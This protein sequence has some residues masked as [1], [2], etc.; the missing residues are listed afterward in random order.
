MME[1]Q[2][3]LSVSASC[4]LC[5]SKVSNGLFQYVYANAS[6]FVNM[7]RRMP[8]QKAHYCSLARKELRAFEDKQLTSPEIKTVTA[9][10]LYLEEKYAEAVELSLQMIRSPIQPT[11]TIHCS[12]LRNIIRCHMAEHRYEDAMKY[13]KDLFKIAD[14]PVKFAQDVRFLFHMASQCMHELGSHQEA[15]NFGH[16]AIESNR[17]FEEVHRSV[18]L[19][20]RA[21]GQ[22]DEAV[23][24]LRRA[25]RYEAPWDSAHTLRTQALLDQLLAEQQARDSPVL[26]TEH[27]VEEDVQGGVLGA[28]CGQDGEDEVDGVKGEED[29][30]ASTTSK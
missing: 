14:D 23:L 9:E 5:R 20:Q 12:L 19:S 17:H 18:A 11:V 26:V 24:T 15:I 29:T 25:V 7:A 22:L 28:V 4:P 10:L 21:L 3:Y 30:L 2:K 1:H 8:S 6:Y 16:A 13:I 27:S